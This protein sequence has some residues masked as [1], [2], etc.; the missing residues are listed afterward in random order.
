MHIK[1]IKILDLGF[2]NIASLVKCI[3][4]IDLGEVS[5]IR[6]APEL[7]DASVVIIPG[8]GNFHQASKKITEIG[9]KTA[10]HKFTNENRG[11][12][13]G[14]CLGAQILLDHSEEAPGSKGLSLIPGYSRHIKSNNDYFGLLPHMGWCNVDVL[15]DAQ[16]LLGSVTDKSD[17]YFVHNFEMIVPEEYLLATTDD[18]VTA[19]VGSA[20]RI[21]G[22]QFHPEK[23]SEAGEKILKKLI[24]I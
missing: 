18:G 6:T 3:E 4:R 24:G 23:S 12:V 1:K 22:L 8:V 11:V 21:F 17:Y 10:L 5:I 16:E 20:A 15:G 9:L 14:I 2:G 13:I 19:I 7:N